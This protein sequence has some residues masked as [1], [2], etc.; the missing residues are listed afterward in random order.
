VGYHHRGVWPE[1]ALQAAGLDWGIENGISSPPVIGG[2]N[3]RPGIQRDS[4]R[5]ESAHQIRGYSMNV[6]SEVGVLF[7][8]NGH[9]FAH[10]GTAQSVSMYE[11]EGK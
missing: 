10:K 3:L 8:D 7:E 1:D 5:E 2:S 6:T 11:R 9:R 4:I